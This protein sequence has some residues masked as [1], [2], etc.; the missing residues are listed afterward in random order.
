MEQT[1][2]EVS[3]S[4]KSRA[5]VDII[6]IIVIVFVA[7]RGIFS[8]LFA[9]YVNRDELSL[10]SADQALLEKHVADELALRPHLNFVLR[11]EI[12]HYTT[13]GLVQALTPPSCLPANRELREEASQRSLGSLGSQRSLRSL[14][15]TFGRGK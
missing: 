7:S 15:D 6:H 2:L 4:P 14:S 8:L 5:N 12:L 11:A 10:R 1:L 3:D 9:A 13:T